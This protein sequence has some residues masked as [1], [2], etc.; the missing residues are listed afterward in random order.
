MPSVGT[1]KSSDALPAEVVVEPLVVR[2]AAGQVGMAALAVT[3]MA[4]HLRGKPVERRISTGETL[5]TPEN[6]DDPK[7]QKLLHPELH[8]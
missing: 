4:D 7:V 6:M 1:Q 5:A 3:S 8:E 2:G